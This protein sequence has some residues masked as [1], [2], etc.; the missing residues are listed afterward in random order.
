MIE[1]ITREFG[2]EPRKSHGFVDTR[3]P[4]PVPVIY[5]VRDP[6]EV[7]WSTYRWFV[8]GQ[9]SNA[10]IEQTLRGIT[11]RDYLRGAGGPRAGFAGLEGERGD[12][13]AHDRGMLYQPIRYWADHVRSYL[14]GS[15]ATIV[16]YETLVDDPRA[17]IERV[18]EALG[19]PMRNRFR[20]IGRDELVGHTPSTVSRNPTIDYWDDASIELLNAEA[21]DVLEQFG[22]QQRVRT[23]ARPTAASHQVRYVSRD[24]NSGYAVAGR[25][26]MDAMAAAGID[27]VWEPQPQHR[28]GPRSLVRMGTS[29][30]L[31]ARY[32][33]TAQCDTTILHTMP[34]HW[35]G[36][37]ELLSSTSYIGHTVWELD[38]L[39]VTWREDL[40]AADRLW[41]PTD[42]NRA[43]FQGAD[44][45]RQ[46][47]VIPHVISDGV[48][49]DPPIDIPD[50][51]TVFTTISAWHPRKRPD[52]TLEAFARAFTKD[53]PV[54][55]IIKTG[56]F[57]DA[58][59]VRAD[60][61]RMTWWQVMQVVRRHPNPPNV[62][63]V[64]EP[65]T[66]EEINGLLARTDCYV[67]LSASEGWGL[68]VFDAATLGTPV[69]TTGFGGQVSYLG[70]SHPGL[71]P[72]EWVPVGESENS[73]HLEPDMVWAAP[74]LDVAAAMMRAT[75][76]PRS[77]I[78]TSAPELAAQLKETYS[79]L[80]V[81]RM[82]AACLDGAS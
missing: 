27:F 42:W 26:C 35:S 16:R 66:D 48:L 69:I 52:W 72:Y 71:V 34:D 70:R 74:D 23:T 47:Q 77:P 75:L 29:E 18:A 80:A 63:L 14:R 44:I 82:I 8:Q 32:R 45:R 3:R 13:L 36:L 19:V 64:T 7:M 61:E 33:P 11:F 59:P 65:F 10:L 15:D 67:S 50:D 62:V 1:Y 60:V 38:R 21:G 81:G 41:V 25:R 78:V 31:R 73:P 39:P 54:M 68:G 43:T 49:A 17:E 5:M 20:P 2:F 4:S 9:S 79:P 28:G 46:I 6:I 53:D 37:R 57:T 30:H 24:D 56:N 12:T 58:W 76:D 22:Y 55:L 51:V 40:N